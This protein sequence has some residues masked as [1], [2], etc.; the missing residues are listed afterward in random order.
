[1]AKKADTAGDTTMPPRN[2][3]VGASC[4]RSSGFVMSGFVMAPRLTR[5]EIPGYWLGT[6][7]IYKGGAIYA[8][9]NPGW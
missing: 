9:D 8:G 5:G 3:P 1:M 6:F 7:R 2:L 4:L